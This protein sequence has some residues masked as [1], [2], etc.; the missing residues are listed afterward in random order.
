MPSSAA[1]DKARRRCYHRGVADKHGSKHF[2]AIDLGAESGRG[3]LAAWDGERV[4]LRELGR[5][6]TS[7]GD[8]DTGADGVRRWQLG[9]IWGEVQTVLASALTETNG[10]LAGVGV[11]SWGVDFGLLDE[12]GGLL[13]A[14]MH[15]R[16]SAN[17]AAM[18]RTL[19]RL[20]AETLW[21]QT[22]IQHLAFNTLFQLDA[23]RERD[24]SLLERA[25]R[26]LFIPDLFHYQLTGHAADV[27]EQTN[28]STS[29]L[30]DPHTRHWRT[31]LLST[32][33]LPS[34]FLGP[35]VPAGTRVG[36]TDAGVPVYAP[37]THDTA[38]AVA[39]VPFAEG[40]RGAFLSSGTWSLL[41]AVR[42]E[43]VLTLDAFRAGF[44]NEGG[45]HKTTRLLKNIM[46]LWLVQECRRS[47]ARQGDVYDYPALSALASE[48][49]AHGPL[50][51]AADAR[52]LAPADM[53]A[54]IR[55]ACTETGQT[56]PATVGE[57]IRCCLESLA[58]AYRVG[59]RD[60]SRVTGQS[61]DSL[62]VVGG[63]AQNRVL[64]QWAA[65]ACGV[66]VVAGPFEVTALGNVLAQLVASGE[67]RTWDEARAVAVAS[68]VPETFLPNAASEAVWDGRG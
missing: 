55:A 8:A 30:L 10:T 49:P 22:G 59:L 12:R 1:V 62:S 37:A 13:E 66:P 56:P 35:T 31:D 5:F 25:R 29:S 47:L 45:V 26:L 28:A 41:G 7:Q 34:Q 58:L 16:N 64:N 39:A 20:G 14:P 43:P 40:A 57:L 46:G 19:D 52:F 42:P 50:V 33:G 21:A 36:T 60:L 61:F 54:E 3:M 38:S 23:V 2:L 27:V 68:S 63:G 67:V 6:P 53:A 4:S 51:D 24:P 65:D 11:D 9:R 44:S 32:L 48:A 17:P 18:K 15:Y